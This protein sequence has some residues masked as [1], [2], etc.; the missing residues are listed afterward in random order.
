MLVILV[1]I[2]IVTGAIS[3]SLR[4][5]PSAVQWW[6][7][8]LLN[9]ST[10]MLGALLTFILIDLVIGGREKREAEEREETRRLKRR[11]IKRLRSPNNEITASAAGELRHRG[12]L[13]NGTL[14]SAYLSHANLR[15]VDLSNADLEGARLT[16][17]KLQDTVLSGANLEGSTL[18]VEQLS[19]AYSLREA[20]MPD[21]QKYDGRLG[22][23]GDV[24]LAERGGV[25]VD[26]PQV[27]AKFYG[28]SVESYIRGQ[29]WAKKDLGD[30]QIGSREIKDLI[31]I[32]IRV[33]GNI[34]F[35]VSLSRAV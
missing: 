26:N 19:Q 8:A 32:K 24:Q 31:K 1:G 34:I 10:E 23:E 4:V 29:D 20:I 18:K 6:E 15:G 3:S 14:E 11:L 30:S 2:A 7:N 33:V 21:G 5:S 22:L 27:M 35:Q 16:R 17:A 12:W 25:D 13:E 9:F 28:V